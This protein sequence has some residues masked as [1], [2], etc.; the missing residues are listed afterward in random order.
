MSATTR[1]NDPVLPDPP[2]LYLAFDLS[3]R[4]WKLAFSSGLGQRARIRTIPARDLQALTAEVTSARTRLRL[5]DSAPL[6][7]CFE[8]GRDGFWLHRFL[9]SNP[10][11]FNLVVDSSS[12]E[13]NRRRRH[14]K[15]DRID[16]LKLL[17]MLIRYHNGEVRVWSVVH[18]PSPEAE[19][20]RNLH[21]ELLTLKSDRTR[22]TNRIKGLLAAQGLSSPSLVRGFPDQLDNLRLWDGAPLCPELRQRLEREWLHRC[23]V[24]DR[25]RHIEKIQTERLESSDEPALALVR[26]LMTLKG[27]GLQSAWLFTFEFFAWRNIQN[28]RQL[29]ALSGFTPTPYQSG[30]ESLDQGI[31]KAGS[32]LVRAMTIQIA[33]GWLHFQP[34]SALTLWY[35]RRWANGGRRM[36]AIGIVAVARRLL[37]ELWRFLDTGSLPEG[38]VTSSS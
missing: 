34:D 9:S 11:T 31:S 10:R 37:I 2:A 21:R 30:D 20:A 23:Y 22:I 13:V 28:R 8:A 5:P 25:I 7:S 4:S 1:F 14:L 17:S 15:T 18:V 19:D 29:A 35:Q 16:A 36:R 24:S 3:N 32:S 38:A 6:I 26:Q 27:V 12:I 33:W